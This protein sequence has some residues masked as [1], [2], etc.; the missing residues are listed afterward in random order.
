MSCG[1]VLNFL[2]LLIEMSLHG[3]CLLRNPLVQLL[4]DSP[5]RASIRVFLLTANIGGILELV[6][7]LTELALQL[8]KL[9]LKLGYFPLVYTLHGGKIRGLEGPPKEL[10][11]PRIQI[12]Q[13]VL[14]V[15][16]VFLLSIR[17]GLKQLHKPGYI[18]DFLFLTVDL[19]LD[20]KHLFLEAL[21]LEAARSDSF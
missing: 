11:Y 5:H 14:N 3:S 10:I 19:L 1:G 13:L 4:F 2:E 15:G 6:R 18:D 8:A 9:I 16:T 7:L 17:V 20:L 12:S 21:E